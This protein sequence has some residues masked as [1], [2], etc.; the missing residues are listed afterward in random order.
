MKIAGRIVAGLLLAAGGLLLSAELR[1]RRKTAA[2]VRRL[3]SGGSVTP[4]V[5]FH[6]ARLE[7]LPLPVRRYF[8]AV[9][10]EGQPAIRRARLRQRGE[11]LVKPEGNRW[12][13]FDAVQHIAVLPPGFVWD[14]RIRMAPGLKVRVRDG[15]VEG[16]GTMSASVMGVKT[17]LRVENT[18]DIAAAAL[19]RYLAETT[20]VPTALLPSAGVSWTSIDDSSARATLTAGPTTVALDFR[21]GADGLVESVFSPARGREVGGSTIP[22]PWQGRWT[23]WENQGGIRIP[24]EGEV[25]W[26]LPE[27]PQPYWRGRVVEV[28]YDFGSED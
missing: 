13:P 18:P 25:E 11:F 15:F 2:L 23:C 26:L 3:G 5:G 17:I 21:F 6:S 27:G 8:A 10:R 9:L 24:V 28:A 4:P 1:W 19:M 14:A 7:N 22:T 20:W 12:A 16:Q